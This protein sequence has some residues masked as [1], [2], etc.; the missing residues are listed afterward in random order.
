M[1]KRVNH[2][3]NPEYSRTLQ[4]RN[5][6]LNLIIR[7]Y[8][9]AYIYIHCT[10]KL[11][12]SDTT[13]IFFNQIF[14]A[15]FSVTNGSVLAITNRVLVL[16]FLITKKTPHEDWQKWNFFFSFLK[17]CSRISLLLA[18]TS[19]ELWRAVTI[20]C[21]PPFH[22]VIMNLIQLLFTTQLPITFELPINE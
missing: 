22:W 13:G 3:I 7:L 19:Y 16:H 1:T 5:I 11:Y 21:W 14:I 18:T 17:S 8:W 9:N 4:K 6:S 10:W 12:H 20:A 2:I 15:D